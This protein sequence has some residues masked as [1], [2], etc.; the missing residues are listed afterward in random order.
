MLQIRRG[1]AE[2]IIVKRTSEWC[3]KMK[4]FKTD[5][6]NLKW[7]ISKTVAKRFEKAID[8]AHCM[9][10]VE[11]EDL[12]V[13]PDADGRYKLL[14]L[15]Q[16][17]AAQDHQQD[18]S[19]L[20]R[21]GFTAKFVLP[22]LARLAHS[23]QPG[24]WGD[25]GA[26]L[27]QH[28][29]MREMIVNYGPGNRLTLQRGPEAIAPAPLSAHAKGNAYSGAKLLTFSKEDTAA[30][31]SLETVRKLTVDY[32]DAHP[33]YEAS[34]ANCQMYVTT[35]N[36]ILLNK[37][38]WIYNAGVL[39]VPHV[40]GIKFERRHARRRRRKPAHHALSAPSAL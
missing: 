7:Q 28:T 16:E 25:M 8:I 6:L 34:G 9:L 22:Q 21:A 15:E 36:N 19:V 5:D 3:G 31:I 39:S 33:M 13:G 37:N 18:N 27:L 29:G 12:N 40:F 23:G 17:G 14:L 11:L 26:H 4:L 20:L 2:N 1:R 38:N 30:Q 32:A 10:L 35:I 24:V